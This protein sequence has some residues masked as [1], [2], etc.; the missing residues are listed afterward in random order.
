[1]DKYYKA[2]TVCML[3]AISVLAVAVLSRNANTTTD[4]TTTQTQPRITNVVF[5][6]DLRGYNYIIRLTI[7]N[8]S[9]FQIHRGLSNVTVNNNVVPFCCSGNSEID[10]LYMWIHGTSCHIVMNAQDGFSCSFSAMP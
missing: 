6:Q 3:V 8:F 1:M 5:A 9:L 7:A 2:V 4:T 10:L